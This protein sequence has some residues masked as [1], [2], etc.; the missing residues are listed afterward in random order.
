MLSPR[1]RVRQPI[2]GPVKISPCLMLSPRARVRQPI[3]GPVK[4][5]PCLMLSPRG[6]RGGY[7][8]VTIVFPVPPCSGRAKWYSATAA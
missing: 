8:I 6:P 1:A 5:S 2:R 3:R 7:F 4:I